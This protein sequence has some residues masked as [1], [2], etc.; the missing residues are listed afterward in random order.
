MVIQHYMFGT[1]LLF[2]MVLQA[3]KD[4]VGGIGLDNL[5][6]RLDLLYPG[7]HQF[8]VQEHTDNFE[9]TLKLKL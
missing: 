3:Q 7:A 8:E 2:L 4:K 6:Q 5:R 9:V 1:S